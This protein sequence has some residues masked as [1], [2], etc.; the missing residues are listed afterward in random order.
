M[1]QIAIHIRWFSRDDMFFLALYNPS[2]SIW[3]SI[4]FSHGSSIDFF[5]SFSSSRS[6]S[7]SSSSAKC[8][9]FGWGWWDWSDRKKPTH[10]ED[11]TMKNDSLIHEKPRITSFWS[12]TFWLI[13]FWRQTIKV[14]LIYFLNGIEPNNLTGDFTI[15][16][17]WDPK[18][19]TTR[20]DG[21]IL[22]IWM[23]CT[24]II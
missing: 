17:W 18:Q 7:S 1:K 24:N 9:D 15:V 21:D 2:C 20:F 10:L 16:S 8:P 13:F 12:L 11:F 14:I 23:V 6:I 5:G 4:P 22:G 19:L 3:A